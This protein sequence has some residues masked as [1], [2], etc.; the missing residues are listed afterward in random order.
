MVS[1]ISSLVFSSPAAL[2]EKGQN[3]LIHFTKRVVA[4][5]SRYFAIETKLFPYFSD[6]RA[7][8]GFLS[9]ENPVTNENISRGHFAFR[10]RMI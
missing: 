9:L 1:A 3:D 7:F 5:E 6:Y 4:Y 10:A 2:T 8:R